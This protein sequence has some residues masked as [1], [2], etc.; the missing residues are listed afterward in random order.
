MERLDLTL[1][2]EIHIVFVVGKQWEHIPN[3]GLMM[4]ENK[5]YGELM[6]DN[7]WMDERL[8]VVLMIDE[9]SIVETDK[10]N[11]TVETNM[12]KLV[13]E[14]ECFGMSF[15]E[16]DKETRSSDGLQP[17]QADLNCVHA[18]NKHHLHEIHVR[19]RVLPIRVILRKTANSGVATSYVANSGV[20][21]TYVANSGVANSYVANSYIANSYVANSGVANSYVANSATTEVANSDIANLDTTEIANLGIVNS[22]TIEIA[23]SDIA[24]STTTEITNSDIANSAT[25]EI[26]NSDIVNSVT[27][28]IANSNIANSD[29]IEIANS[30][31]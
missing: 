21:N 13:V 18:L 26:A 12:M 29:T 25:T 14:I 20:S 3:V 17:K 16:F 5:H 28:E 7:H 10:V 8:K 6:I 22:A 19:I 30:I 24:N 23:N 1:V 2:G 4:M 9:L 15:D 31:F 27:T 11:Y